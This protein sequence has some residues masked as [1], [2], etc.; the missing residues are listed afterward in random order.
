M[1]WKGKEQGT[2]FLRLMKLYCNSAHLKGVRCVSV[3]LL[4]SPLIVTVLILT[5]CVVDTVCI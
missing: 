2:L 5:L 4:Q 3:R 1:E